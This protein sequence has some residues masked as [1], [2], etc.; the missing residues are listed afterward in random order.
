MAIF[1]TVL[2]TLMAALVVAVFVRWRKI[3][4]WLLEEDADPDLGAYAIVSDLIDRTIQN[5][6]SA[7]EKWKQELQE[8]SKNSAQDYK[9]Q[10]DELLEQL[11]TVI[12]EFRDACTQLK[13]HIAKKSES[14]Q[15]NS[16]S[17]D[18]IRKLLE[19]FEE[20]TSEDSK[21][22][23][24]DCITEVQ[25]S[26][27]EL[28]KRFSQLFAFNG[29]DDSPHAYL[30][31]FREAIEVEKEN[32]TLISQT[33]G[34]DSLAREYAKE[35]TKVKPRLLALIVSLLASG[36]LAANAIIFARYPPE[37][38][39]EVIG[40]I[41]VTAPIALLMYIAARR[42]WEAL[43]HRELYGHKRNMTATYYA[44]L[45][46]AEASSQDFGELRERLMKSLIDA[47]SVNPAEMMKK[48]SHYRADTKINPQR[49]DFGI[50]SGSNP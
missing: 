11:K 50:Q 44:F 30:E 7:A 25:N 16:I 42:Y 43:R 46:H 39:W 36:Y 12:Q 20:N 13:P 21:T 41:S 9:E 28:Q 31:S 15:I 47:L 17:M 40:K 3:K 34:T 29:E 8:L 48:S 4:D 27:Q 18:Q 22:M 10:T 32:L 5:I 35:A 14:P 2:I 24:V 37:N 38:F 26:A 19:Y 23:G 45:S 49:S 6:D 33:L 1:L